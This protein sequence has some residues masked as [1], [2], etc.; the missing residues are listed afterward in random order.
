MTTRKKMISKK[1]VK[2]IAKL[3]RLDLSEQE[4]EKYQKQLGSI[5]NY[6]EK[7]QE[8]NTDGIKTADGGIRNLE[9]VWREDKNELGIMNYE[10]GDLIKMAP[11]VE[12]EQVKVKKI[13]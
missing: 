1:E 2:H 7:L 6:V 9:N 5:L 12:K 4:I 11:E 10:S 3:A 13:L 8:V